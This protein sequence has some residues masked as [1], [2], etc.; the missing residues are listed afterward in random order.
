M[1]KLLSLNSYHYRR[2]G[3]DVVYFEHARIFEEQGWETAMFAMHHPLNVDTPWSTYFCEELEFGHRYGLKDTL[4]RAGRVIYSYDAKRQME[5]L[6]RDFNPDVAHA[7]CIYHH[8]SPSVLVALKSHGIPTVMTAHD[9]KL[10]CPAYKMLNRTGVC[11]KCK[12]GNLLNVAINRC[13]RD[14]LGASALVMVESAIHKSLGLYKRYLDKVV[15]PSRF[16]S[17]KLVEWGWSEDQLVYIPN[18]INCDDYTVSR[19]LGDGVLY[20]GR[21]APEKGVD[22]LIKAANKSGVMLEIAG[23]GPEEEALKAMPEAQ[24]ANII[25]LGRLDGQALVDA[26]Q[27]ARAI[28]LPSR[29]YENAPMS[30]LEAYANGR[31]VIGANIGGIPELVK[32]GQTGYLSEVDDVAHLAGLLA[33]V[34][35]K[36][37]TELLAMGEDARQWVA[38]HFSRRAYADAMGRLYASLG[39]TVPDVDRPLS[40]SAA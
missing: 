29:W 33:E 6:I 39:V 25:F 38:E 17:N 31:I 23:T 15:T 13:V 24:A 40:V 4:Q 7:H 37:D 32:A 16:F 34:S 19:T 3:S 18:F 28:V 20:F 5:R 35:G 26:V 27:R 30:V 21:L 22:T 2:G 11:E 36:S 14:S 12:S 9:L 10:A 1:A 8:L